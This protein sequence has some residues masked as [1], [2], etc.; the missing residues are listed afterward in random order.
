ML[1]KFAVDL[2]L[3]RYTMNTIAFWLKRQSE[4][5]L[6][7]F[8]RIALYGKSVLYSQLIVVFIFKFCDVRLLKQLNFS[9]AFL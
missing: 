6:H 3:S 8:S 9:F 2:R 1:M 5:I 4:E 7:Y